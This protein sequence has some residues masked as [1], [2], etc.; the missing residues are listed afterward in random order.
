MLPFPSCWTSR[1]SLRKR[2]GSSPVPSSRSSRKRIFSTTTSGSSSSAVVPPGDYEQTFPEEA[3]LLVEVAISSLRK[4]RKIKAP[5]YAERGVPEYWIVDVDGG[6]VEVHT[7]PIEGRYE[8]VR[9]HAK[10]E[11][12]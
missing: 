2:H 1:S 10:G 6:A 5:L 11:T 3:W 4:D 7:K 12:I 8:S 9:R